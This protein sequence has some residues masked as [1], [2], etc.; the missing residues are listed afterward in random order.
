[1]CE[2]AN[3][4]DAW[5]AFL[6]HEPAVCFLDVRMPGMTGIEVA[7]RIDGG[8]QVVL[9]AAPADHAFAAFDARVLD[10]LVKPVDAAQLAPLVARLKQRIAEGAPPSEGQ[11]QLLAQ[12][13]SQV[14]RPA[15]LLAIATGAGSD[16]AVVRVDDVVYFEADARNTRLVLEDGE[17]L[18]RVALKELVAQLDGDVFRQVDRDLVVNL[19]HVAGAMRDGAGGMALTLRGRSEWLPVARHFQDQFTDR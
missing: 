4:I 17:A 18:A 7:Q 16:A 5:D 1:V 9:V 15:P 13:A 12:L 2:C 10:V 14:R 8:A 11:R 6:E 3:G 19:R